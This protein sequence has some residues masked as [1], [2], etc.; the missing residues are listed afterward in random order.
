MQNPIHK[1]IRQTCLDIRNSITLDFQRTT[2]HKICNRIRTLN[3]YRYAKRIALYHAIHGEVDLG[4]IWRSAPLHGKYCYFPV[5]HD[6]HTLSFL[7]AT[8]AS[9]F[10]TNAYG[11]LEP[12]T[13]PHHAIA[14]DALD[15][16]FAPLVAFDK[17]GTRLGMGKGYYDKA[18]AQLR[19]KLLLGLGYEFQQHPFIEPQPWDIR[20]DA[21]AT[22]THIYWSSP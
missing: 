18:L 6:N 7:P 12:D 13:E 1:A 5:I 15:I 17:N 3:Q 9:H 10:R 11:I 16:I 2:S 14:P 19:P 22:E 20:M 21:I 8:P 4:S